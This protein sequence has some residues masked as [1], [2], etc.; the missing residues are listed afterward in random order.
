MVQKTYINL[1]NGHLLDNYY[2]NA[3]ILVSNVSYQET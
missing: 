2:L 1:L 3:H